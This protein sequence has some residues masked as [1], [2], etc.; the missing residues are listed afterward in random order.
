M[1]NYFYHGK[2]LPH[3]QPPGGIFFV[4]MRLYGSIPKAIIERLKLEYETALKEA[5]EAGLSKDDVNFM[6]SSATHDEIDLIRKKKEYLAGSKF[7]LQLEDFLHSNLNE[8]HWLSRPDIAQLN[9]ENIHFYANRYYD[10]WAYTIM[11]N[12]IHLLLTHRPDSPILWKILQDQKKYSGAQSN[13][14]LGREGAFWESESY[15]HWVRG[16]DIESQM[17]RIIRYILNNPV[18]AKLVKEWDQYPW[19]YCHPDWRSFADP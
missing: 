17:Q 16:K 4:T 12:H 11:S 6:I 13:K 19:S 5:A 18:K 8:P 7:F 3:W 15:D 14:L 10:L 1:P 2:K 9:A